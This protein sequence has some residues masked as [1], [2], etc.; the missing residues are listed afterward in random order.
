MQSGRTTQ[1][2][3][4][5]VRKKNAE[6]VG[7]EPVLF[8]EEHLQEIIK[9]LKDDTRYPLAPTIYNRQLAF[10]QIVSN[11]RK[12]AVGKRYLSPS[13][14]EYVKKTVIEKY[15]AAQIKPG[16]PVMIVTTEAYI[17]A[18]MQATLN[19][20]HK[21]G[22]A[23][24]TGFSAIYEILHVPPGRKKKQVYLHFNKVMTRNEIFLKR[25]ELVYKNIE[26]FIID[27][28]IEEFGN[29]KKYWWH[30]VQM[31]AQKLT[32]THDTLVMRLHL[33]L[34]DL[35]AYRVSLQDIVDA[36]Y[37]EKPSM[38]NFIYGS[39]K[40][41]IID[42]VADYDLVFSEITAA[43]DVS[44]DIDYL[45]VHFRHFFNRYLYPVFEYT[46]VSG[47]PGVDHLYLGEANVF[48]A[49]RK[50][51]KLTDAEF[52]TLTSH[53]VISN[54]VRT[55]PS[56]SKGV[57]IFFITKRRDVTLY[58]GVSDECI[59][60]LVEAHG[61]FLVN[62]SDLISN[63][64]IAP[65][66]TDSDMIM[67]L[68]GN[69]SAKDSLSIDKIRDLDKDGTISNHYYAV[70]D[71]VALEKILELPD[72]DYRYTYC[73]NFHVM[74]RVFGIEVARMYH[75]YNSMEIIESLDTTASP[76]YISAFSDVVTQRGR[77]LGIN[78]TGI[79]KQAGGFMYRSTISEPNKILPTAALFDK[80]GEVI[81]GSS[82][83]L[84]VG[85][86][87]KVGTGLTNY[88]VKF[89]L[90]PEK[91]DPAEFGKALLTLEGGKEQIFT[92][93]VLYDTA[94]SASEALEATSM[95]QEG[96][97]YGKIN[98]VRHDPK[99]TI[100]PKALLDFK[101]EPSVVTL[102][103]IDSIS[104]TIVGTGIPRAIS[105]LMDKYRPKKIPEF[106]REGFNINNIPAIPDYNIKLREFTPPDI[107]IVLQV[108]FNFIST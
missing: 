29:L 98:K 5:M 2:Q 18:V 17:A 35:I 102:Q 93:D 6:F 47:I 25:S 94:T 27:T 42:I 70:L 39:I 53:N 72:C 49:F 107:E 40:D 61:G 48:S 57:S 37:T 71:S 24:D 96:V 55:T 19:T 67:F 26:S 20:F 13:A 86:V 76:G 16:F 30:P 21:S 62:V 52:N 44:E 43:R 7:E 31:K 34:T 51:N 79:A 80:Q 4:G 50:I 9:E 32:I 59:R 92:V 73:N 23:N 33:N 82:A 105:L 106:F 74:A 84:T 1:V 11:L 8:T 90:E 83:A 95:F 41:A 69:V 64:I 45:Q 54:F 75:L 100:N 36:L 60:R 28:E 77:F 65:T 91:I 38:V 3:H 46:R 101:G 89:D 87:P 68:P 56:L 58:Q 108:I 103:M 99:R 63:G 12:Q 81:H 66:F 97:T 78:S 15:Y 22:A 104:V 88:G 85:Q 14:F 10:D